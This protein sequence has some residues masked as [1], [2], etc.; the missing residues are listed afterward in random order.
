MRRL[1][2][3]WMGREHMGMT[4]MDESSKVQYLVFGYLGDKFE[5]CNLLELV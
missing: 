4:L 3:C 1:A 2:G 5:V